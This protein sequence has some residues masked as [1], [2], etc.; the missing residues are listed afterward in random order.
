MLIIWISW[1]FCNLTSLRKCME[2]EGYIHLRTAE[3]SRPALLTQKY[4]SLGSEVSTLLSTSWSLVNKPIFITGILSLPSRTRSVYL[5][6]KTVSLLFLKAFFL[7]SSFSYP[8]VYSTSWYQPLTAHF[9]SIIT[10]FFHCFA[11]VENITI[12]PVTQARAM[13]YTAATEKKALK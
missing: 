1:T 13:E 10:Y 6:L 7:P 11:S 9:P 2:L 12:L 4:W 5:S 8:P 3:S